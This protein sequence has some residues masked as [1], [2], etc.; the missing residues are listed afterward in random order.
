M[1]ACGIWQNFCPVFPGEELK[2]SLLIKTSIRRQFFP[3]FVPVV[4]AN[5]A[6]RAIST[7]SDVVDIPCLWTACEEVQLCR[8]SDQDLSLFVH[9]GSVQILL[10]IVLLMEMIELEELLEA[11]IMFS[12]PDLYVGKYLQIQGSRHALKIFVPTLR[13]NQKRLILKKKM[14][15]STLTWL[16]YPRPNEPSKCLATGFPRSYETQQT[17]CQLKP[18]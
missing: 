15:S 9:G 16:L 8:T 12:T 13:R 10:K 11:D 17:N 2:E 4:D 3:N 18:Q 6:L 7:S 1:L 14:T 5:A